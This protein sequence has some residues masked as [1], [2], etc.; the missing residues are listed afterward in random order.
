MFVFQVFL[1]GFH[2]GITPPKNDM[3]LEKVM[4]GRCS[5]LLNW[6]LFSE[7]FVHL[8]GCNHHFSPP[9]LVND[10]FQPPWTSRTAETQIS[11]RLPTKLPIGNPINFP[12]K[13]SILTKW[14]YLSGQ[15]TAT[16]HDQ[17]P[18]KVAEEGKWDPLF[19]G[20]LGE[21]L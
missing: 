3:S 13:E 5:F 20:N 15:I 6:S 21:I 17:K 18:Q 8:Q 1:Y 4:V 11:S 10:L 14:V 19:Q 7:T 16:S 2:H 9:F 12:R